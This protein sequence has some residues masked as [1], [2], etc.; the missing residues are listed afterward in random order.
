[1][2]SLNVD[3]GPTTEA[4]LRELSVLTGRP[5]DEVV[6]AAVEEYIQRTQSGVTSIPGVNPADVWEAAAQADA[7]QLVDHD[8]LFAR[9]RSK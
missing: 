2:I 5:L 6:A 4:R 9:L 7:G 8:E 1:M 3:V